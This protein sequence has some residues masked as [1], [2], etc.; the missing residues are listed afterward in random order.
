MLRPQSL[1]NPKRELWQ[2]IGTMRGAFGYAAFFSLFIN[3]L[4]LIPSLYMLQ[5]YDRVLSSQ[6]T[7]TLI[8]LTVL[9]VIFFITMGLLEFVRSRI[10]VRV[11]NQ[12]DGQLNDRVF[13]ALFRLNLVSPGRQTA[14]AIEDLT[15]IRQFLT[16]VPLFAFFDT[17]WVPIYI[18]VLFLFHPLYGWFAVFAATVLFLLAVVNE[19]STKK[20]L[21]AA[22]QE[23]IASRDTVATNLRNA[24]VVHAMG[25]LESLRERWL[26]KHRSFLRHQ[27]GAS[28]RAS[29]FGNVSK[30]ARMMFQSMML[31][32]GAYLVIQHELTPGM[33][34]A[35]SIVMGRG[36]APLDQLIAGWKQFSSARSSFGRLNRLL[37]EI[38]EEGRP[39]SLPPP[40]GR[41]GVEGLIVAPPGA[42][43]AVLRGV[44]FAM[45]PGEV[46]ALVGPSAA[47]KS[48]LARAILGVW[49]SVGGKVR[50]DGADIHNWNR[51]ELGE[52]I[53]Y[54]PQDVELF[55]GT[56]AENICR[57]GPVDP[58]ATV[59]AAQ[60]AGVHEMILQLPRGYD[61]Q[62]GAGGSALSGGQRQRIGLAR[63]L[64]SSPKLL[65][66]DEPNSNLDDQ[67]EA[68]LAA[69]MDRLRQG[70]GATTLI[71]SHRLNV[72]TKVDRIAILRD[73]LL[74]GIGPR[75]QVLAQLLPQAARPA[76]NAVAGP[77]QGRGLAP[78]RPGAGA[79]EAGA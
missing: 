57:F 65:I 71:I 29:V 76:Q 19:L 61:T 45:E 18:G 24:E 79:A 21:A 26:E 6:S 27:A 9:M 13:R 68:A 38:P 2:T 34:I 5:L 66:L 1:P 12:L 25:M 51:Q 70:G 30:T 55:S 72:L 3:L 4:M 49:P 44:S 48:T 67:G 53:G 28:D 37:E 22:N 16:G 31:G 20:G 11:G 39:M 33:M 63:A 75:D 47:G 41:L 7:D 52:H 8:G 59:A 43:A 73:G 60:L 62:I 14:Q 40:V 36:L 74:Q 69:A 35:G 42:Q 17:P 58:A 78:T 23:A 50:L 64:Y 56:V 77:G 46:V 32:L 15:Q 10:L 54:L